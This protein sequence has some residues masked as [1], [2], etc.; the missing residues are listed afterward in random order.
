MVACAF[1]T[2]RTCAIPAGTALYRFSKDSERGYRGPPL[3]DP[4]ALSSV[5]QPSARPRLV[6]TGVPPHTPRCPAFLLL[7]LSTN[8]RAL[9]LT[10]SNDVPGEADLTSCDAEP[11]ARADAV[12]QWQ[13]CSDGT[14]SHHVRDTAEI[15]NWQHCAHIYTHHYLLRPAP[16]LLPPPATLSH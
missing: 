4:G 9:I 14:A 6:L 12:M 10:P 1:G 8:Q 7:R 16:H 5:G 2:K 15:R 3:G 13:K 11:V